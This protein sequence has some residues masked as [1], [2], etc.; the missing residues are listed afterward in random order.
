MNWK[1]WLKGLVAAAVASASSTIAVVV[2]DP[3]HFNPASVGGLKKLG[4]VVLVSA[5]VGAAMYLKQ[6]PVP[7]SPTK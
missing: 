6:S 3:E 4:I 7:N 2:A 5:I 1:L